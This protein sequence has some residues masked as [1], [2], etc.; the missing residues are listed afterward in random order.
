[1]AE[2]LQAFKAGVFKAL[3]HPT[4]IRILE[5][6]REGEKSVSEMQELLGAEGSTV[7]QQLSVLRL[8]NLVETRRAGNVIFYRLRDRQVTKLLDVAQGLYKA[9]VTD[10][11]SIGNK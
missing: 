6:L 3:A 7:S 4:R 5:L 1:M 9:H 8:T 2:S 10:L 11:L